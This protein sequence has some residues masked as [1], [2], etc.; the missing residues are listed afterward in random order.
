[1]YDRNLPLHSVKL[2]V[3]MWAGKNVCQYVLM[4]V[5]RDGCLSPYHVMILPLPHTNTHISILTRSPST[6]IYTHPYS[7]IYIRSLSLYHSS[8]ICTRV[9]SCALSV[10]RMHLRERVLCLIYPSL[11]LLILIACSFSR[12]LS[13]S[14]PHT[15]T[16]THKHINALIYESCYTDLPLRPNHYHNSVQQ[17]MTSYKY[18][19]R[20]SGARF[21]RQIRQGTR[22][23]F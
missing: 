5:Y 6:H 3:C 11:S 4:Y 8:E 18:C 9:R 15:L 22:I 14:L 12:S 17:C 13:L 16:K 2:A 19:T 7:H 23:L 10:L 1:M 20:T 21:A